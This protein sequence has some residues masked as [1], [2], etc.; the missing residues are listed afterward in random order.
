MTQLAVE[1]RN[2]TTILVI[3]IIFPASD[4]I[5]M[6]EIVQVELFTNV[7]IRGIVHN[8]MLLDDVFVGDFDPAF[9]SSASVSCEQ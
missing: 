5:A 4:R 6:R 2:A 9:D 1:T 3:D 7:G 8:A